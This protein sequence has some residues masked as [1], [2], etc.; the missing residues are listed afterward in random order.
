MWNVDGK[1]FFEVV[2]VRWSG[3]VKAQLHSTLVLLI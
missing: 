1:V 3:L 2:A